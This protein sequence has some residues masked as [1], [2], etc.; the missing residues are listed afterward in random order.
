MQCS[1][2]PFLAVL[3]L[4]ISAVQAMFI[5]PQPAP[6]AQLVARA[7]AFRDANP[8]SAEAH[9]TL[10]RIH[11]LA[12]S[13]GEASVPAISEANEEGKPE[14]PGDWLLAHRL[15][16][17]RQKRAEELAMRDIG[18]T[19]RRPPSEKASAFDEARGK[20]ARQL[21]EQNWRPRGELSA[22]EMLAHA[23]AAVSGFREAIRLDPRNGLY[24]L[25]LASLAEEFAGWASAAK[26]AKPPIELRGLT[27]TL[28]RDQY[29]AAFRLAA[30]GDAS[31]PEMPLS[32]AGGLVSHEAGKAYLRVIE[33]DRTKRPAAIGAAVAEVR[34]ALKRLRSL[35]MG[36]ITPVIFA[37]RP[38]ASV[39]DLLAPERTVDFDLRGY[40]P[41]ERW[42]WVQPDTGFFVWDP[43][44][45]GVIA[46][47]SQLFGSYTFEQFFRTGY[48]ALAVLDSNGDGVLH[49]PELH[50]VRAWFDVDANGRSA[51]SE[52]HDLADLGI[53][54][55]GVEG[56]G[57]DGGFPSD[58]AG[59]T[60]ND[61]RVLPSW[62][63]ITEPLVR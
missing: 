3:T 6:V 35:R 18:E 25:G 51:P 50:G 19:G 21:E 20:R 61:G 49:G 27:L 32:G 12:F 5:M 26:L 30:A 47:A 11:Y 57:R 36:A 16:E 62:D 53:V 17:A 34:A 55:V 29:L 42:S 15:Y 2:L 59:V 23:S 46:S 9:Y 39:C 22:A 54:A 37:L 31:L 58:R 56:A 63:W 44:R 60:F 10:A 38:V 8:D 43:D 1:I 40:G 14:I 48:A 7:T 4:L 28:A 33:A 52:V 45:S 13:Q 41:A 24:V